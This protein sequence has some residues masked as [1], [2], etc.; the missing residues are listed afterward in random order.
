MVHNSLFS[1]V[2]KP[3]T[4]VVFKRRS[5][6]TPVPLKIC[7]DPIP[8]C[9]TLPAS[10]VELE[11]MIWSGPAFAWVGGSVTVITTVSELG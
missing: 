9:G 2:D 6:K 5:T 8:D 10:V 11:Q 1:P 4:S 7:H 3:P